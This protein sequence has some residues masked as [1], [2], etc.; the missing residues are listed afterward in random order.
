KGHVITAYQLRDVRAGIARLAAEAQP[1]FGGDGSVKALAPEGKGY[2]VSPVLLLSR[3][4]AGA[5]V[6]HKDEVFGPVAT[7]A[8]SSSP[9]EMVRRGGGVLVCS[10]YSDDRDFLRQCVLAVAPYHGRVY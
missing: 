4:P 1:V 9:A 3:D 8:G 6:M 2:F 10:V 5:K 7:L